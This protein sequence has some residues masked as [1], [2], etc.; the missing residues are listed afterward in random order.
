MT[1]QIPLSM[2]YSSQNVVP[3]GPQLT[4]PTPESLAA[5]QLHVA[6]ETN[7]A[8]K[9]GTCD[10]CVLQELGRPA[11]AWDAD[12]DH[13]LD[14]DRDSYLALLVQFGLVLTERQAYICP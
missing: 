13:D 12:G 2:S 3:G 5:P 10:H 7:A 6:I 9:I 4:Q 1:E 14:F 11:R 8:Y